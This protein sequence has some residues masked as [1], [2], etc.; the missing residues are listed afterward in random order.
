MQGRAVE[1]RA[2]AMAGRAMGAATRVEV[3]RGS[4]V[5]VAGV[6]RGR[7][8]PSRRQGRAMTAGRWG[9]SCC[10]SSAAAC[11]TAVWLVVVTQA[12]P[13]VATAQLHRHSMLLCQAM[14]DL[15]HAKPSVVPVLLEVLGAAAP[16]GALAPVLSVSTAITGA[17]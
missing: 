2:V 4:G 11:T 8:G 16:A 17:S 5:A 15:Y 12:Q 6:H 14:T 13:Q 10:P 1:G 7:R 9:S 3:G